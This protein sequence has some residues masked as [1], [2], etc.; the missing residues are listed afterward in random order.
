ML[1]S[2]DDKRKQWINWT[3]IHAHGGSKYLVSE[4]EVINCKNMI[5]KIQKW[6][7]MMML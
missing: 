4:K 5:K 1:S 6:L 3:E 2:N 7:T